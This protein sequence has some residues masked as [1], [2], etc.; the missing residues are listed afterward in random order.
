[1][2]NEAGIPKL[3]NVIILGYLIKKTG[4]FDKDYF[5]ECIKA[6]APKAKPELGELNAKAL[7][8]GYN[9]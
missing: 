3:A 4:L 6:S 2:A 5:M 8:L 7:E 1:M 9:Y